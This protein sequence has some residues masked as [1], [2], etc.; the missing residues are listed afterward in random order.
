MLMRLGGKEGGAE[1]AWEHHGDKL[2]N[3]VRRQAKMNIEAK[4]FI[5]KVLWA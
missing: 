3:P 1:T 5:L 4:A 2:Y